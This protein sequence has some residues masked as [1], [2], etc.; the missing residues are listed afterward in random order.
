[1]ILS[2][3]MR[4]NMNPN[5]YHFKE[6][7]IVE[8]YSEYSNEELLDEY[9]AAIENIPGTGAR[10]RSWFYAVDAE[11]RKRLGINEETAE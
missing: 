6:V 10:G 11:L 2:M 3:V 4:F 9:K 7:K 5:Y 1:M 8:D